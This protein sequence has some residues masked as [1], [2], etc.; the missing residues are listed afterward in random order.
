ML[1]AGVVAVIVIVVIAVFLFIAWNRGESTADNTAQ[2]TA[3]STP[4]NPNEAQLLVRDLLNQRN[5]NTDA[6]LDSFIVKWQA[7]PADIRATS[8]E[9]LELNQLTTA[10]AWEWGRSQDETAEVNRFRGSDRN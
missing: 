4:N 3:S 8:M 7:L 9:S 1:A 5:W 2:V 10:R 6:N